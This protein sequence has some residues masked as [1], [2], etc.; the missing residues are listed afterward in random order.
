[1]MT[2]R[3]F[4]IKNEV[5][6]KIDKYWRKAQQKTTGD[7]AAGWAVYSAANPPAAARSTSPRPS[8]ISGGIQGRPAAE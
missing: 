6:D 4:P 3:A 5:W 2:D 1:M 7:L 8:R